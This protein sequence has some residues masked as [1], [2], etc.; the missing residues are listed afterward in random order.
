MAFLD[1]F[2]TGILVRKEPD[3]SW[4]IYISSNATKEAVAEMLSHW[5]SYAQRKSNG[6]DKD[7]IWRALYDTVFSDNVSTRIYELYPNFNYSDPDT[8]YCEDVTAF[9]DSFKEYAQQ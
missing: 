1:S 4:G 8:T 9:I 5:L 3:D 2:E 7:D 6:N